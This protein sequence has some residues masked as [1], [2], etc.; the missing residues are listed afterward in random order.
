[1]QLCERAETYKSY[2]LP[3][4]DY[5]AM[6]I[7]RSQAFTQPALR[8]REGLVGGGEAWRRQKKTISS[9]R[10]Y[11]LRNGLDVLNYIITVRCH[12]LAPKQRDDPSSRS[13]YL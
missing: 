9:C 1:M 7:F 2:K 8:A 4:F 11:T 5:L 3:S 13:L 12:V 10:S 6:E